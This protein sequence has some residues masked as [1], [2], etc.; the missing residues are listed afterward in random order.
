[1]QVVLQDSDSPTL[2]C[3]SSQ[4][5]F[6]QPSPDCGFPWSKVHSS[7]G[8]RQGATEL[9]TLIYD[10]WRQ[11]ALCQA[12]SLSHSK[13]CSE[14]RNCCSL[15]SSAG[16]TQRT[17]LVKTTA[18]LHLHDH[19]RE[20]LACGC[21]HTI[22]GSIPAAHGHVHARLSC[23]PIPV[24]SASASIRWAR[25]APVPAACAT[26]TRARLASD[27]AAML[28]LARASFKCSAPKTTCVSKIIQGTFRPCRVN[29]HPS[30]GE[31]MFVTIKTSQVSSA[32]K[33]YL[34]GRLHPCRCLVNGL[35]QLRTL[36]CC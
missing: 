4:H 1:M 15:I 24:T 20:I 26:G 7:T 18:C 34:D 3:K 31:V 25:L 14:S 12:Q 9:R 22:M 35:A 5:S 13:Q 19:E 36:L 23:A 8:K 11:W 10:T 21:H 30:S 17:R 6:H 33:L 27:T 2:S 32:C 28:P 29:S 16:D